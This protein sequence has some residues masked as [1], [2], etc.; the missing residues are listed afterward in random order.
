[1]LSSQV[2]SQVLH[3]TAVMEDG[4]I[5]RMLRFREWRLQLETI[6]IMSVF[7]P[8]DLHIGTLKACRSIPVTSG[9]AMLEVGTR[10]AVYR[11]EAIPN[12]TFSETYG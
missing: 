10:W 3:T 5:Q 4:S 1:M 8:R 6:Y 12:S 2:L 11:V 7:L 9:S